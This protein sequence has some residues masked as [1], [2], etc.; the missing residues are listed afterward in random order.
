MQ[1][2][3]GT[4][5]LLVTSL[6]AIVAHARAQAPAMP[7]DIRTRRIVYSVAGMD[8]VNVQRD[9]AFRA[10]DGQE[11]KMDVYAPSNTAGRRA[12]IIFVRG[13]PIPPGENMQGRWYIPVVRR[14]GGGFR[15]VGVTFNHRY[16]APAD[17]SRAEADIRAAIDYVRSNADRASSA[18]APRPKT[19]WRRS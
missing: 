4:L 1:G 9:L 10:V 12:A 6:T 13:G 16:Y 11:L 7:D 19:R 8:R 3:T 17:I 2:K 5:S 14:T 18:K 15:I